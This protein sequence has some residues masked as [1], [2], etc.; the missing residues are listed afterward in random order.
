M[1]GEI[2]HPLYLVHPDTQRAIDEKNKT[3]LPADQIKIEFDPLLQP[4]EYRSY[5]SEF[6]DKRPMGDKTEV[7]ATV[8]NITR[9]RSANHKLEFLTWS[10][11]QTFNDN[12]GNEITAVRNYCGIYKVPKWKGHTVPDGQGSITTKFEITGW[13]TLYEIPFTEENAKALKDMADDPENIQ[14]TIQTEGN[15]LVWTV[16]PADWDKWA[17]WD[18]NALLEFATTPHKFTELDPAS[19]AYKDMLD[20]NAQAAVIEKNTGKKK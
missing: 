13:Q 4:S 20:K 5:K 14:T 18:F 7:K 12:L 1:V 11:H 10:E 19:K 16:K 17:T 8:F 15:E 2:Y 6:L 9:M 3:M